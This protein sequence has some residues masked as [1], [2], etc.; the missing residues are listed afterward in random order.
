MRSHDSIVIPRQGKF[1]GGFD[2]DEH[3][4]ITTLNGLNTAP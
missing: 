2:D 1:D 3:D 4:D